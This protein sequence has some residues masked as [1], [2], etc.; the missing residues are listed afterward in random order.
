MTVALGLGA[1]T[2][3]PD[4]LNPVEW[5]NQTVEFFTVPD[6]DT[7]S[8]ST[9]A[10]AAGTP[11]ADRG[12]PPPGADKPFPNLASVPERP[13]AR[14]EGEGPVAGGLVADPNKPRYAPPLPRQD[15]GA[16]G[17]A[18][19]AATP[20]PAPPPPATPVVPVRPTPASPAPVASP[21]AVASVPVA[22]SVTEPRPSLVFETYKAKLMEGLEQ[23]GEVPGLPAAAMRP[24]MAGPLP[25]VVVSSVGVEESAVAGGGLLAASPTVGGSAVAS[26]V[27]QAAPERISLGSGPVKV[28]TIVFPHGSSRLDARDRQ[29]LRQVTQLLRQTGGRVRVVGHASSRTRNMDPV[30]HKMTNFQIS[31]KRADAVASALMQLGVRNEDILL[32]AV[33]DSEPIFYEV[34]PSGE[35]GNRRTEVFI[36][37]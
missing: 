27:M 31:M 15:E 32:G 36:D 21:P 6:E 34:M 22:P 28:A 20:P 1:C 7:V 5:W 3:V 24:R 9:E 33:S 29:I 37:G 16:T 19:V 2:S 14:V 17:A 26:G 23:G 12:K 4:A 25:T 10:P 11:R 35:A 30:L 13:R 8:E 18:T